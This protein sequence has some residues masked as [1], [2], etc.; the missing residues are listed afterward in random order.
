MQSN[1]NSIIKTQKSNQ[2]Y[3]P[4]VKFILS[5][6]IV[7]NYYLSLSDKGNSL[8]L[9]KFFD[10]TLIP[11]FVFITAFMTKNIAWRSWYYNLFSSIIIYLTFQ[12][13]DSIPFYFLDELN[14]KDY[15]F[16]PKYGVWFFLAVPIWQAIFLLLPLQIKNHPVR[17]FYILCIVLCISFLMETYLIQASILWYFCHYFPF[18]I[19]AYLINDQIILKLRQSN[20]YIILVTS[21]LIILGFYYLINIEQLIMIKVLE[22]IIYIISFWISIILCTIII[23]F[24]PSTNRYQKISNNALSIYLIHPIVCFILLQ[25]LGRMDIQVNLFLSVILT[26]VTITL[27]IWLSLNPIINWFIRP[28]LK[29][30]FQ[31]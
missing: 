7:F 31:N 9:I 24:S 22:F 13:I 8:L 5:S 21:L 25:C 26:V 27:S 16:F 23:Y 3:W 28:N 10:F 30:F 20:I 12:T 15:L 4:T 17:L 11:M 14:L 2:P 19:I 29:I 1:I 18:F 6:F